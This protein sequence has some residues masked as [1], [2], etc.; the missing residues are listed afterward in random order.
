MK[1]DENLVNAAIDFVLKRFP[2]DQAWE[3]AAAMYT[4][5]GTI[6]ISTAPEC[7][8]DS[9]SLCHETGAI[10]E[11]HK[12]N[13]RVTATVCV[14]RDDKGNF[15]IL[16]PCG[17]CQERLMFWGPSVQAAV[18]NENDSTKWDVKTLGEIQPYYWRNI[19]N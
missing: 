8:N 14:S 17:V 11:A 6:L 12:L 19:L 18:P 4:E 5:D 13:K 2:K 16:T 3:G 9:V 1:L 7:I 10:C 15:I